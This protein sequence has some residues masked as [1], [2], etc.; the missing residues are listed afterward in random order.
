MVGTPIP[1][2]FQ[3]SNFPLMYLARIVGNAT[4]TIK[5][6]SLEGC[7]LLLCENIDENKKGTNS[8]YLAA[9]WTGANIGQEVFV[10]TDGEAA[11]KYH[12]DDS[13]PIRNFILG[14]IDEAEVSKS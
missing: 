13:S 12:G 5:H 1:T 2:K 7:R 3:I 9:D 8:F 10:T 11:H 14:I 6:K 4:S